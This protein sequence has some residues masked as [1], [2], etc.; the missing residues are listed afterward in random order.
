MPRTATITISEQPV[1]STGPSGIVEIVFLKG[2]LVSI[3]FDPVL[4]SSR[5]NFRKVT[6]TELSVGNCSA[7]GHPFSVGLVEAQPIPGD[8]TYLAVSIKTPPATACQFNL[9]QGTSHRVGPKK[10]VLIYFTPN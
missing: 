10:S 3:A 4:V 6:P 9:L 5:I 1:T 7:T 8:P 2:S